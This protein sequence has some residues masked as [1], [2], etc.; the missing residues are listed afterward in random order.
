[1]AVEKITWGLIAAG[2]WFG[3]NQIAIII[4][5]TP[6]FQRLNARFSWELT[7]ENQKAIASQGRPGAGLSDSACDCY[8][9]SLMTVS[10]VQSR[11]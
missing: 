8:C 6:L 3:I 1:M 2:I 4:Y 5:N 11:T 9:C 10:V 7:Y